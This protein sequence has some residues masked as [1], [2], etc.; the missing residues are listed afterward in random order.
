MFPKKDLLI[1]SSLRQNAR[2][3]L[4]NMSKK[5][6]IPISTIFDRLKTHEKSI[7]KKHT[8]LIDFEKLGFNTRANIC[9]KVDK[10]KRGAFREY[11]V[12]HQNINSVFKINNGYDF[13][14]EAIFK[15]IKDMENFLEA[16]EERFDVRERKVY[17]L[18]ED[19]KREEFMSDAVSADLVTTK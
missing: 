2:I 3:S 1:L 14:V 8:S 9:F 13:L 15:H 6:K 4:T 19:I 12:R 10:E 5:T 18:I 16:I 11:L 7:I 17:Y